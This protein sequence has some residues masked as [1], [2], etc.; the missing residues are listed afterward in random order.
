VEALKQEA[1]F[2]LLKPVTLDHLKLTVERGITFSQ[3]NLEKRDGEPQP[4]KVPGKIIVGA[5]PAI[6]EVLNVAG[7]VARSDA[8]IVL[9]GE[10]G[11]GKEL[12]VRTVH[13]CSSRSRGVFIR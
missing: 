12:F 11:T 2:Y 5:G 8:N 9:L 1:L 3:H 13:A 10:S 6:Q 4:Q 7:R